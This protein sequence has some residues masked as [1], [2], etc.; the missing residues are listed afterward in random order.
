VKEPRQLAI[1]GWGKVW[2]VTGS[3]HLVSLNP[4]AS[5]LTKHQMPDADASQPFGVAPD[6]DVV[7][8]TGSLSNKVGMVFPKVP[9]GGAFC[10]YPMTQPNVSHPPSGILPDPQRAVV[11]S[12]PP[13]KGDGKTV[14]AQ[15]TTK[16][17]G[18]YIEAKI[19]MTNDSTVPLGISPNKSKAQGTFFYAVGV[20]GHGNVSPDSQAAVIDRVGFVRLPIIKEKIKHPR[21][22]DDKDD[23]WDGDDS[24]HGWHGHAD[25]HDGDDD[26]FDDDK[27]SPQRETVQ[28]SGDS[29]ALAPGQAMDFPMTASPTTLAL[30]AATKADDPLANIG[31]DIVNTL[32]VV[33]A[34]SLPT[35]GVAVAQLALP[36]AGN[37][38]ARVHNYGGLPVSHTPTLINREPWDQ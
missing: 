31:I 38:T 7:G 34:S 2:V 18:T 10:V 12:G 33:V 3:G 22:D 30:I 32:G 4:S 11:G 14:D 24:W 20:N 29:S 5:C 8:Y 6:D 13:I 21:D 19:N 35:P 27:D 23:G 16:A 37:Y 25:D 17:D 15:F 26:G 36:A 9:Q 1:D 28:S